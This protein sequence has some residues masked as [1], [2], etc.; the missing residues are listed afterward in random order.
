M[1]SSLSFG[2]WAG[3]TA[4]VAV[5]AGAWRY[6]VLVFRRICD[7]FVCRVAV[8]DDAA[9]AVM[10][11]F[12][13]H[14]HRSPFGLRLF[15][16]IQSFVAPK[17]RVEVIAFEGI[18]SEPLLFW[19][20]RVPVLIAS[21]FNGKN[22][23]PNLGFQTGGMPAQLYFFRWTLNIDDLITDALVEYNRLRQQRE[24]ANKVGA[25]KRF[26]VF[27]MCGAGGYG[28]EVAGQ[29]KSENH[30]QYYPNSSNATEIIQQVQHGEVRLL[31]WKPEELVERSS[32]APPFS[33]HPV[34]PEILKQFDE[35]G[36]F[37]DHENWFRA[38]GIPWRRGYLLTGPTGS[39]KST[40]VRNIAIKYD[41]PIYTF[42]L[43][44]YD[45]R[46]FPSDWK[47]AM[48]NAPAIALIEDLDCCF[49]GRENIAVKD[50]TRDS[51]TFDCLLNTISGVGMSDGVLL[52]ITTNHPEHLDP[53]LGAPR[54]GDCKS[55]RPGRI[56]RA[57]EIGMMGENERRKLAEIILC[58]AKELIN[59]TVQAG[60]GET[61]A[62]FQERCTLLAMRMFWQ[63]HSSSNDA[64][65]VRS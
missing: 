23:Q 65:L 8:K 15:G 35:I 48:Q 59:A 43:S 24:D 52:F 62:Q 7:V 56:D 16:G 2:S 13:K 54:N 4:A 5:L 45:N 33:N 55:T 18:T 40:I 12:W 51:L 44:T 61:A 36:V 34:S 42:D 28:R 9:R 20:R 41:L 26:N 37:L 58:D 31:T 60:E 39:G 21:G 25:K 22:D 47:T 64:L 10:A 63:V 32:D 38:K 3:I 27:R 49:K 29:T 53:A 6:V 19:H 57:I 17:K 14:G 11:Y 46:S 1:L 30:S 50:K